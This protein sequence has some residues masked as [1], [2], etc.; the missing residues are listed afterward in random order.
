M[1]ACADGCASGQCWAAPRISVYK[2]WGKMSGE[3]DSQRPLGM[4]QHPLLPGNVQAARAFALAWECPCL[5]TPSL[6]LKRK[7]RLM[8]LSGQG[9]S[10]TCLFSSQRELSLTWIEASGTKVHP[11]QLLTELCTYCCPGFTRILSCHLALGSPA[12]DYRHTSHSLAL[13]RTHTPWAFACVASSATISVL[14]L[15]TF[16]VW[17]ILDCSFYGLSPNPIVGAALLFPYVYSALGC[18]P[19]ATSY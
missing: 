6:L 14:S 16:L 12:A 5:C 11:W 19:W 9:R 4:G 8:V 17:K 18:S 7:R 2:W 10:P 15:Q 1:T 3:Y 13:P